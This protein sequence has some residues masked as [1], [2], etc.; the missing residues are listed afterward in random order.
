MNN[1]PFKSAFDAWMSGSEMRRV[2][3]RMK[4]FTYGRQWDDLV[5]V[6]DGRVMTEGDRMRS[7]GMHPLTNNLLR[8][9]VKSV[10]G[11]F[12]SMIATGAITTML[13][14]EIAARNHINEIDSRALEEFLISGCA[15]QRVILERRLGGEGVWIDNVSPSRFFFNRFNDPRGCDM[16]LVG[17]LHEWSPAE[18]MMRFGH[19]DPH[20]NREIAGIYENLSIDDLSVAAV[21]TPAPESTFY[22]PENRG[23]CRVIE[24]WT[25]DIIPDA[26]NPG[27]FDARW[28][29]RYFAPDGTLLDQTASPFSSGQ[30]P[31]AMKLYPLTDGEIHPFIED[32]VDNQL[33]I[34]RTITILDKMMSASAKSLL[35]LPEE[36]VPPSFGLKR[37]I[38]MWNVPGGVIPISRDC[39]RMPTQITTG[40][41]NPG[42]SE[43]LN[44][45]MS[46]FRQ[47][48]GV[49]GLLQGQ[50]TGSSALSANMYDSQINNSVIAMMDIFETFNALRVARDTLA[51]S[52]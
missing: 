1:D 39:T 3:S 32:V 22:C 47:I 25:R 43:L 17:M 28:H 20:R 35:M 31:F 8:N 46:M 52:L 48:S 10:V 34:N 30:H 16:E 7:L 14:D 27:R 40:G 23:R 2:R 4:N 37:A 18:V 13:P 45:E 21:G 29:G 50:D 26:D 38:D 42:A 41:L 24:V 44:I 36:A 51:L 9:L 11:R 15:I 12:R 5:T 19:G 6:P 33:H 49:S